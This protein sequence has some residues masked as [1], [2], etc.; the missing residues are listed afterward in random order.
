MGAAYTPF[1]CVRA[2]AGHRRGSELGGVVTNGMSL[3]ARDGANANSA[4][5]VGV[6][7]GDM[8]G[9]DAPLA[10]V[11]FQR[12]WEQLAFKLGGGDYRAPAQTVGDFL[13]WHRLAS[14][15][16]RFTELRAG[17]CP[18]PAARLSAGPCLLGHGRG[19]C[20]L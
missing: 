6:A 4:I 18:R 2:G 20:G 17:R 15:W 19:T 8:G 9:G 12:H 1:A 5:L 16:R 14:F 3:H 7:P 13:S 11:E 10:G